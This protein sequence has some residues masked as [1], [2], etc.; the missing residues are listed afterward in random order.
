MFKFQTYTLSR[1]DL[2]LT[3][4]EKDGGVHVDVDLTTPYYA[5]SRLNALRWTS[6]AKGIDMFIPI[7]GKNPSPP[8]EGHA[9]LGEVIG[10]VSASMRQISHE[11]LK[12]IR[13]R[14]PQL[15]T[16]VYG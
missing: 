6:N 4:A 13:V 1:G 2:V 7:E 16:G 14:F 5:L 3:V 11:T 9:A 10:P 8:P 15:L 12:S